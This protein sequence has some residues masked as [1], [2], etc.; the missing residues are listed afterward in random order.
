MFKRIL[1]LILISTSFLFSQRI[2]VVYDLTNY[3]HGYSVAEYLVD[4]YS[5]LNYFGL[6]A[7]DLNGDNYPDFPM[8]HVD[9]EKDEFGIEMGM[10]RQYKSIFYP[11]KKFGRGK[12]YYSNKFNFIYTN[13]PKLF[14][15]NFDGKIDGYISRGGDDP[16]YFQTIPEFNRLDYKNYF[17]KRGA[18]NT[19]NLFLCKIPNDGNEFSDRLWIFHPI[20]QVYKFNNDTI[21]TTN[22][23][24]IQYDDSFNF[25]LGEKFGR[26]T[27]FVDGDFNNDGLEDYIVWGGSVMNNGTCVDQL[28]EIPGEKTET[29]IKFL[30][31]RLF[32]REKDGTYAASLIDYNTDF[33]TADTSFKHRD[34]PIYG[35]GNG[36]IMFDYDQDGESEI[37]TEFRYSGNTPELGFYKLNLDSNDMVVQKVDVENGYR[38]INVEKISNLLQ[39]TQFVELSRTNEKVRFLMRYTFHHGALPDTS[40]KI[41]YAFLAYEINAGGIIKNITQEVFPYNDNFSDRMTNW[42]SFYLYDIDNDGKKDIYFQ[43]GESGTAFGV[44]GFKYGKERWKWNDKLGILYFKNLGND[45]YQMNEFIDFKAAINTSSDFYNWNENQISGSHAQMI[46]ESTDAMVDRFLPGFNRYMPINYDN[47]SKTDFYSGGN[48]WGENSLRIFSSQKFPEEIT[49]NYGTYDKYK[50]VISNEKFKNRDLN[51]RL[52]KL[53]FS[54]EDGIPINLNPFIG[55]VMLDNNKINDEFPSNAKTTFYDFNDPYQLIYK[56]EKDIPFQQTPTTYDKFVNSNYPIFKFQKGSI[57]LNFENNKENIVDLPAQN[58]L[59]EI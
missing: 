36:G 27:N 6:P 1:F 53:I 48:I 38:T 20:S 25:R 12:F 3:Q 55:I 41:T 9:G 29:G 59:N 35:F 26:E 11:E 47:D 49:K 33:L 51:N 23:E 13:S 24:L 30:G 39:S 46:F 45:T 58:K 31:L 40:L 19:E 22:N 56:V 34:H 16:I 10:D 28:S 5:I 14:D 8:V 43:D 7:S 17:E 52:D 44:E 54:I 57:Y 50:L 18:T 21:I 2:N 32:L 4:N 37:F 15:S 42:S